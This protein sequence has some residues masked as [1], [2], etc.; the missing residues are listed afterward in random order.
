MER[1]RQAIVI[2]N[3]LVMHLNYYTEQLISR[4]GLD[5]ANERLTN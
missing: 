5:L 2:K 4:Q 3:R 1:E